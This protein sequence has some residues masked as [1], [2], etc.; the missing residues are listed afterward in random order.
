METEGVIFFEIKVVKCTR[1]ENSKQLGHP[2][3]YIIIET[4]HNCKA[5][6]EVSQDIRFFWVSL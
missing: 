6:K 1:G 2:Y 5:A 4:S 3:M